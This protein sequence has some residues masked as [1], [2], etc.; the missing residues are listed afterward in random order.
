MKPQ[1]FDH[2]RGMLKERSG[3]VLTSDKVYLVESRLMP[4][5]RRHGHGGLEELVAQL[6][7]VNRALEEE[8]VDAMTTKESLFFRD[9][10]PFETLRQSVLPRLAAARKAA[11]KSTIRI[12]SAACSS[13]Q[14]PFS[15]A[16]LLDEEAANYPGVSF[17]I[18]ASDLSRTMIAK[19]KKG[20]YTQFEVQRGLPVRLLV[21]HFAKD[22]DLWRIGERIRDAVEFREFNLLQDFGGLG[23]FDV[24]LCR[25]VLLYFDQPTKANVLS[26]L[27]NIVASDGALYLGGAES[28]LGL[29]DAFKPV[30]EL[31]GVYAPSSWGSTE[32]LRQAG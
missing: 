16:M 30:P 2:L 18:V 14:E 15:V 9:I 27:A 8:V 23:R 29:T 5:A 12:W 10:K 13:G 32:T 4:V 7:K 24:V 21:K 22:G 3:L 25:N 26:R 31:R 1:D 19:A 6:R 20:E 11:G 28:V 17:E